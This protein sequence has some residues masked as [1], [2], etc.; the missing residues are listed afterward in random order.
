[1]GFKIKSWEPLLQKF[2][3]LLSSLKLSL[4]VANW[5]SWFPELLLI[6]QS[7]ELQTPVAEA[8]L[9]LVCE[10]GQA[11]PQTIK[12]LVTD[13]DWKGTVLRRRRSHSLPNGRLA[14]Q[15]FEARV[16]RSE[17]TTAHL[18]KDIHATGQISEPSLGSSPSNPP[19][20]R[21]G[22]GRRAN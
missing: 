8:E 1:M 9:R 2:V 14:L 19:T 22:S 5:T 21:S 17:G 7:F 4:L 6:K 20:M 18:L 13:C 10:D 12:G 15:S 11:F 3:D 16:S